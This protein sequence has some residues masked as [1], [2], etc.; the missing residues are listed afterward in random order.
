MSKKIA[1]LWTGMCLFAFLFV[2]AAIS[3]SIDNSFVHGKN[4]V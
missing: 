1:I 4:A 2:V 3:L